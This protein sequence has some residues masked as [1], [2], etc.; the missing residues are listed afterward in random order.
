MAEI[1]EQHGRISLNFE[2]DPTP[3]AFPTVQ[4]ELP[5]STVLQLG[6]ELF[7]R[8][9][10]LLNPALIGRDYPGLAQQIHAAILKTDS[11]LR[12]EL[13]ANIIL[14]GGS[15]AFPGL[16]ER[17]TAELQ[18]WPP[19]LRNRV[20]CTVC[21]SGSSPPGSADRS[22]RPPATSGEWMTQDEYSR[23]GSSLVLHKCV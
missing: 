4:Y 6:S 5:D 16:A 1:K 2:R 21:Q 3:D 20:R 12:A 13:F 11:E 15:T 17:L 23:H 18:G 7:S 22:W 9:E 19:A 14:A 8:P 10:I